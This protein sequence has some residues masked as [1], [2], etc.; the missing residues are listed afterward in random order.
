M[1]ESGGGVPSVAQRSI[2]SS[3]ARKIGE[4]CTVLL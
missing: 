1:R 2:A 4:V 3:S